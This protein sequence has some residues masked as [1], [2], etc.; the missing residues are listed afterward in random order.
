MIWEIYFLLLIS[1]STLCFYFKIDLKKMPLGKLSRKQIESAYSILTE[2]QKVF[3]WFHSTWIYIQTHAQ[4]HHRQS[5]RLLDCLWFHTIHI[6]GYLTHGL[7]DYQSFCDHSRNFAWVNSKFWRICKKC[8]KELTQCLTTPRKNVCACVNLTCNS[9]AN[10]MRSCSERFR[11]LK[12]AV[13]R[14]DFIV[15]LYS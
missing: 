15:C 8:L 6:V 10:L 12:M 13:K 11:R 4:F 14:S 9:I 3:V 1:Y 2:A 7:H 5:R